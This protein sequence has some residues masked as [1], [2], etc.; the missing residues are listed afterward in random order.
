MFYGYLN[1]KMNLPS[2]EKAY[3]L[4]LEYNKT[5]SLIKHGL[6]V[7]GIMEHFASLYENENVSEWGIIGL[8]HDIDY[9][10]FPSDHCEKAEEI[11]TQADWPIEAIRAVKSHGYGICTDV[12]PESQLEKV[13]FTIDELSGLI[14]ATALMRPS[15]SV[16]DLEVKSVMKKWKTKSFAAGVNRELITQ[17]AEALNMT[18][19]QVI[20]ECIIGMRKISDRIGL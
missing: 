1:E 19:Q 18:I 7:E 2:R 3:D 16:H 9:E 4:F 12:K 5:E 17:G 8:V 14:T 15:K 6:T 11:L 13:L 20:E 10:M